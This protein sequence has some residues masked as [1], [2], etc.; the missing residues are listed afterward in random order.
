MYNVKNVLKLQQHS[1]SNEKINL[2]KI[3]NKLKKFKLSLKRFDNEIYDSLKKDFNRTPFESY[4]SEIVHVQ[5]ELNYFIKNIKKLYKPKKI[6]NS[7]K[8]HGYTKNYIIRKPY[9]CMLI[10][11]PFS[12]PILFSLISIIGA[13][14]SGNKVILK[15]S[16]YAGNTNIVIRKIINVVFSVEEVFVINDAQ[17]NLTGLFD[18]NFDFVLFIGSQKIG[19]LVSEKF[20]SRLIPTAIL[21]G[22]K[23]PA[24]ID[25]TC[26]IKKSANTL[27]WAKLIN[28]GQS[29]IA[30]DY[31]LIHE[32]IY[33]SFLKETIKS[34][35]NQFPENTIDINLPCIVNENAFN[36]LVQ[37]TK[38][39]NIIY[40]K[41]HKPKLRKFF[42]MIIEVT[43]TKNEL[44]KEEMYGPIFL[45]IKYSK[46]EDI[47][48]W[49]KLNRCP[50]SIYCF[51]KDKTFYKKIENNFESNSF[52][53]NDAA[54]QI[55]KEVQFGGVKNSG[56]GSFRFEHS[57]NMFTYNKTIIKA[58]K[59]M[60]FLFAPYKDL[61]SLKK[62]I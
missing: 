57:Y 54:V 2:K 13:F 62:K 21:L 40:Q 38:D 59:N 51:S 28:A 45:F 19:K 16:P 10:M 26:D 47:E 58:K 42:P 48:K 12:H 50:N 55:Y 9:G 39:Q 22:G 23:C 56:H 44:M 31:F 17:D 3:I 41:T 20:A 29:S 37:L 4:Y 49:I 52:L 5:K 15:L 6:K 35:E 60:K 33:D 27:T 25:K 1:F 36:R 61:H 8:T 34:I 30:P 7:F 24:I 18:F 14:S 11:T 53:L 46:F 43:N 32:S